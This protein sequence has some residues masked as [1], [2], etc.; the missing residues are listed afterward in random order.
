MKLVYR[1]LAYLICLGVVLQAAAIALAF[2]GLGSWIEGGGTLDRSAMESGTTQFT[3][4]GGLA[5]HGTD[6][7]MIIPAIGLL[8]VISSFFTKAVGATRWALLVLGCIVVQVVLGMFAHSY[9]VLGAVHGLFAFGVLAAAAVAAVRVQRAEATARSAGSL[10]P[11]Q[12]VT[13]G[14][15][16]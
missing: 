11:S 10:V 5:F 12:P 13:A 15:V 1:I 4:E 8:L 6:G 9:Y 14:E 3:G 7:M 16:G 2:F